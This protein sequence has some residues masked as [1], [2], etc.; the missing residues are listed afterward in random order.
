MKVYTVT[1]I[2]IDDPK[3]NILGIRRTPLICTK[4]QDAVFAVRN[5]SEDLSDGGTYLYAVVEESELNT[6]RPALNCEYQQLWFKYNSAKDEYQPIM[7]PAQFLHQSGFGI[8]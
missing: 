6:I 4:L 8:G 7:K 2:D 5:D 1:V 3:K